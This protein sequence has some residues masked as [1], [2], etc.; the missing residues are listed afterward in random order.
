MLVVGLGNRF[1][2]RVLGREAIGIAD[3]RTGLAFA[4]GIAKGLRLLVGEPPLPA[5]AA[6]EHRYPEDQDVLPED[7][8]HADVAPAAAGL[9]G[10]DAHLRLSDARQRRRRPRARLSFTCRHVDIAPADRHGLSRRDGEPR[11]GAAQAE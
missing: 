8:G 9:K 2:A 5:E 6:L 11:L 3:G 10:G 7:I 1:V 4:E